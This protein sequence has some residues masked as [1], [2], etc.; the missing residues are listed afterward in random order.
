MGEQDR[1]HLARNRR[2]DQV[3]GDF[4]TLQFAQAL[5]L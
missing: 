4:P 3:V 1:L 5:A 2:P